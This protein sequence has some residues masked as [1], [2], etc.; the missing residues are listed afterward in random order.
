M[1]CYKILNGAMESFNGC[2]WYLGKWKKADKLGVFCSPGGFHG[3]EHP[4]LAMLHNPVHARIDDPRLFEAEAGGKI[5]RD[6]EMKLKAQRMRVVLEIRVPT[7]SIAQRVDYGVRCAKAVYSDPKW[8]CWADSWLSGADKS[9]LATVDA[10]ELA[11][12]AAAVSR[13]EEAEWEAADEAW[14]EEKMVYVAR[15]AKSAWA[16]EAAAWAAWAAEST[17]WL[18]VA[19]ESS[20]DWA[21]EWTE[22]SVARAALAATRAGGVGLIACAER[23]IGGVEE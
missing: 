13:A 8:T 10:A 4:L 20:D 11:A 17:E 9:W 22:E 14:A 21:W 6:G 3:Y 12:R 19:T 18:A 23:A 15:A 5:A 7:I 16:A 1:K 2:K